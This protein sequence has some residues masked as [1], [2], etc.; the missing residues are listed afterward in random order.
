LENYALKNVES[1]ADMLLELN[2]QHDF[3]FIQQIF[4]QENATELIDSAFKI[5][6]LKRGSL[7]IK[8]A[9]A[10]ASKIIYTLKNFVRNGDGEVKQRCDVN[11]N[12]ETTLVLYQNLINQGIEV[13]KNFATLPQIE[14]FSDELVQ[15]W[16][17]LVHNAIQ[18]M[19]GKGKIDI[20][21]KMED[22]NI[23]VSIT[24]NG[25]GIPENVRDKIFNQY[26]TTKK[27]GEGTGLGLD[28]TKKIIEKH[29][30]TIWFASEMGSGTTFFV[31]LPV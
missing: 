18:A 9:T 25:G 29:G 1:V 13:T 2:L 14:A 16:T 22:K 10:R 23:I 27:A 21:T 28:I 30:G 8:T 15:V 19:N 5:T 3:D 26:F 11:E 7:L 12:I 17:N 20:E 31:K 24:D 4:A 6:A